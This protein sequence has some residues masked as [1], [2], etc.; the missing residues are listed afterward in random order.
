MFLYKIQAFNMG[1]EYEIIC[2]FDHRPQMFLYVTFDEPLAQ[3]TEELFL[4]RVFDNLDPLEVVD[5]WKLSCCQL[6]VSNVTDLPRF[7]IQRNG[8]FFFNE[9]RNR[10]RDTK[11][12]ARFKRNYTRNVDTTTKKE[13]SMCTGLCQCQ[14]IT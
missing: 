3:I 2:S 1:I 8:K 9:D 14:C 7:I 4:Q 12:L 6:H 11:Y 10:D 13:G 5:L